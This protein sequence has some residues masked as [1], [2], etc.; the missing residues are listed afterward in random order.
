MLIYCLVLTIFAETLLKITIKYHYLLVQSFA[1][2]DV[3]DLLQYQQLP[4]SLLN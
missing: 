1:V 4:D 3:C 2:F